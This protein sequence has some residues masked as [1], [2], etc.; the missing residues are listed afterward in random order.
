MIDQLRE[1]KEL[2]VDQYW[3]AIHFLVNSKFEGGNSPLEKFVLG[4]KPIGENMGYDPPMLLNSSEVLRY[5]RRVESV[6]CR[7][8]T[9]SV[10]SFKF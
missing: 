10:Q 7:T 8:N 6:F 5:H 4:G 2:S 9:K 1:S 3:Q